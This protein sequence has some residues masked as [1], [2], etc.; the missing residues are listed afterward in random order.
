MYTHTHIQMY[1][2]IYAFLDVYVYARERGHPIAS[3][4][5]LNVSIRMRVTHTR[6]CLHSDAIAYIH[7]H[8]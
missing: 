3:V 2:C 5:C 1:E 8:V 7:T 4:W 6:V